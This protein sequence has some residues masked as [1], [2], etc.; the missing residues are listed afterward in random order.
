MAE[1]QAEVG[2]DRA[3]G[4]GEAAAGARRRRLLKT[5]ALRELIHYMLSA[6]YAAA[7]PGDVE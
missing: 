5:A 1:G 7:L 6:D 2:G 3:G 4:E